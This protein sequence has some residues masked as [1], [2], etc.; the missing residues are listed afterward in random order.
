MHWNTFSFAI[1]A[2]T[3][4]QTSHRDMLFPGER[5]KLATTTTNS[6]QR[7]QTTRERAERYAIHNDRSILSWL[8]EVVGQGE[9]KG[10]K[11]GC[12][13]DARMD[14]REHAHCGHSDRDHSLGPEPWS[15]SSS[16]SCSNLRQSRRPRQDICSC[17]RNAIHQHRTHAMG[18]VSA[19]MATIQTPPS[20]PLESLGYPNSPKINIVSSL[21]ASSSY[22]SWSKSRRGCA[23]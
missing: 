2:S 22:D 9:R 6:V 12:A 13:S 10:H 5:C 8:L 21:S 19:K 14:Q 17:A 11:T 1:E 23:S 15:G 20:I 3:P 4:V 7:S 16:D 18:S